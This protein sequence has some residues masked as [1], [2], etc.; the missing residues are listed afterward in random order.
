MKFPEGGEFS[1]RDLLVEESGGSRGPK[2]SKTEGWLKQKSRASVKLFAQLQ[3]FGDRLVTAH[4]GALEVIQQA[5]T[6][7][8]HHQQPATGAVILLGGLQVLGQMVDALR[9]QRNLHIGGTGIL[10]VQ[11][12]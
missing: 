9:Q 12:E 4:V 10:R 6:L 2:N 11:L 7:A 1:T 5:A 8:D 3:F